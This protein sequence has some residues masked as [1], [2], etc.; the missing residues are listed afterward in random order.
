M[1]NFSYDARDESGRVVRGV[2]E[3]QDE[4]AAAQTLA[5]QGL[6]PVR[7]EP[8]GATARMAASFPWGRDRVDRQ[9]VLVLLRE[10]GV[11]LRSGIPLVASLE[12]VVQQSPSPALRRV[13]EDVTRRV[14]EGA[15]L[16]EALAAHPKIFPKLFISMISVGETAGILEQVLDRLAQM[17][18]K[19][20]ETRSRIQSAL[21]YPVVLVIFA[22]LLL[23]ALL[24]GVLPRFVGVFESSQIKLPWPTQLLLGFSSVVRK[25]WWLLLSGAAF[26][27]WQARRFYLSTQGRYRVDLT[28]L[29][30]PG[31]GLLYRKVLIERMT[32]TLGGMLKTGVPLLEAINVTEKTVPNVVFQEL[33]QKTRTAVAGGQSLV[34]PWAKS[35]LFPPLVLQL[36]SVGERTGQLDA[37][38]TE[39]SAFYEPEVDLSIRQVTTLMEPALLLGMGLMVGFIALSV[40][41]PIFQLVHVFRR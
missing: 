38:L 34:E 14:Q 39:V 20:L 16:S 8:Q 4:R 3:A 21:I 1:P 12:G 18:A 17:G 31:F 2:L 13:L 24:I 35:K 22:F 37:M 19:E 40:L 5:R 6:S 41:L 30:L 26:G 11:L 32:R 15:G 33:L 7:I 36:V 9:E 25:F 28:L 10:L 27:I 23:N 29:S